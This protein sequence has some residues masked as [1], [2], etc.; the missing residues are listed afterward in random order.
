M[1][2]M[3]PEEQR[4]FL[5]FSDERD[6]QDRLRIAAQREAF[7][8][9]RKFGHDEGRREYEA[10]ETEAW[11]RI[12][13]PFSQDRPFFQELE[14]RRWGPGGREHFGDPRPADFV[15]RDNERQAEAGWKEPG[16]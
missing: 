9:G 6:Q 8:A 4:Q 14:E 10:Q 12:L 2:A 5:E 13:Q 3:T 15:G 11:R 7:E 16:Q 1:S